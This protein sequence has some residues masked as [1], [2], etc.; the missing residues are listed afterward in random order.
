MAHFKYRLL[1]AAMSATLSAPTVW[2]AEAPDEQDYFQQFP[3]VLSASRL[4][5]P[6]SEAPNAMTV[7]DR[8]MIVASG[9]RNIPDLFRLV[10]GMYVG[11]DSGNVPFVSYHG[12]TDQYAR[13]MQVLVDGRTVYLPPF[14]GVDWLDVPLSIDDIERIEVIRGPAAASHGANSL[15]GVISIITR[16]AAGANGAAVS[17]N[18]G[19]GGITDVFAHLGKRGEDLDYRVT[20]TSRRDDGY[21]LKV[22]NDGS[23]TDQI[24]FRGN[25]R[26]NAQDSLDVQFGYSEGIRGLGNSLRVTEPFRE[27]KTSSDFQQLDWLHVLRDG[28]ELKLNYY[29]IARNYQD[30]SPAAIDKQVLQVH[31]HELGMQHTTPFGNDN[32]LVWGGNVRRD[33]AVDPVDFKSPQALSISQLFA[34]GELRFTPSLLANVGTMWEDDGMGHRNW[35]PRTSLNYHL[36]PEHTLRFGAS[37]AYRSPV[38]L[39][40][41]ADTSYTPPASQLKGI[42]SLNPEKVLSKEIGYMGEFKEAG[43]LLDMRVYQ[44]RVSDYIYVDPIPPSLSVFANYFSTEFEGFEGTI[45]Y[46]WSAQS[47]LTFN[48]A[49]QRASCWASGEL[50]LQSHPNPAIRNAITAALNDLIAECPSIVSADSGSILLTQ[51][52]TPRLQF[53]AGY[54]H[55]EPVK[56]LDVAPARTQNLMRRVDLRMAYAFGK[57]GKSGSGHVAFVV[58]NAF[59]D[60]YM[61]Y[62]NV[63]QK[64]GYIFNRR[65]YLSATLEF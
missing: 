35:S 29:H 61:E 26:F 55:Q 37:V 42:R 62:T 39:E 6:L 3:V 34:H 4:S 5:Q 49:H 20:L 11:Y 65:A 48:Y 24:S 30:N 12:A 13:R 47:N 59:Q 53:N 2:A 21:D 33:T 15:Q 25:Y 41:F 18:Q 23:S 16:D 14:G 45:K 31:R 60:N 32:R 57:R 44:D 46:Q 36:A 54:Y 27:S 64:A 17:L 50:T 56:I 19:N 7:I 63:P 43:V 9:F 28:G 51:Q 10:P 52:L 8:E 38:M 1:A 40:Q 22:L 58:Q